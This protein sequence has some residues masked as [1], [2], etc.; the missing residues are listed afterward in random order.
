MAYFNSNN[1]NF[2]I[3]FDDGGVISDNSR[4]GEQ[5]RDLIAK[6]FVPRY[7]GTADEWREANLRVV[8]H[9]M[10]KIEELIDNKIDLEYKKY[11]KFEDENWINYM[12]DA[13]GIERPPIH[14]YYKICREVERWVTSQLQADIKGIVDII[15]RLKYEGY[16]LHT[17]SGHTSWVLKAILTKMGVLDCF[18]NLY[19]PDLVGMMKGGVEFYRRIFSHARVTPSSAIV[20]DDNPK[21]LQIVD[22]L[23]AYTIQSCAIKGT[24]PKWQHFYNN[25]SEL[26]TLLTSLLND[27]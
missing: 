21:L 25:P 9:L 5:W 18:N 11:Q 15:K 4:K 1:R 14:D 3:F 6:Y 8:K 24:K 22:Q 26:P 23:G 19:G 16:T 13:V 27:K 20:I 7:G 10:K 17:A 12:F 2:T